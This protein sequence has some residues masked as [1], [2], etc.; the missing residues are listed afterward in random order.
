VPIVKTPV[1]RRVLLQRIFVPAA[2]GDAASLPKRYGAAASAAL[3]RRPAA[4]Y[5]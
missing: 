4:T 1:Q 5:R 2:N 3:P